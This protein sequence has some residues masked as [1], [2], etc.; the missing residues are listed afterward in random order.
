MPNK[1]FEA[2]VCENCGSVN[3]YKPIGEVNHLGARLDPGSTVPHGAC[4]D[5][6]CFCYAQ[7]IDVEELQKAAWAFADIGGNRTQ[8]LCE[9]EASP[10][11]VDDG[12]WCN[13]RVGSPYSVVS[14]AADAPTNKEVKTNG[15]D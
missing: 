11:V 15:R 2:I 1:E 3:K 12:A 9:E 13:I 8:L 6:G 4:K 10:I 14:A 5:C 7:K